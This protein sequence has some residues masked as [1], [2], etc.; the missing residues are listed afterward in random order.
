[1]AVGFFRI[2]VCTARRTLELLPVAEM[3]EACH[4]L[5]SILRGVSCGSELTR[6]ELVWRFRYRTHSGPSRMTH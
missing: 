1:M 6:F 5:A 3:L 2:M 4:G